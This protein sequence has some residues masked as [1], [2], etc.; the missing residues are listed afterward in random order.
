MWPA[1]LEGRWQANM[2]WCHT[3]AQ[4]IVPSCLLKLVL[5]HL[6]S[7]VPY[8][9][10]WI[11]SVTCAWHVAWVSFI[12]YYDCL[13][14]NFLRCRRTSTEQCLSNETWAPRA[15]LATSGSAGVSWSTGRCEW[16]DQEPGWRGITHVPGFAAFS[17]AAVTVCNCLNGIAS[18]VSDLLHWYDW[19]CLVWLMSYHC[20]LFFCAFQSSMIHIV[21]GFGVEKVCF[22]CVAFLLGLC[23]FA[24]VLLTFVWDDM[25]LER[26]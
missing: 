21:Q 23:H 8:P 26:W 12:V 24:F 22:W 18:Q 14:N 2:S 9:C 3:M 11:V 13:I 1:D 17:D 6:S 10:I 4:S 16:W 20:Q 19:N 15:L 5:G 25:C 7:H